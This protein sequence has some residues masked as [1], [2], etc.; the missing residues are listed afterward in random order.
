MFKPTNNPRIEALT[1]SYRD[2]ELRLSYMKPEKD[3]FGKRWCMWCGV[4][5]VKH[6]NRKYCSK[7][8]SL[9]MFAWAN[10]QKGNGL[11]LLL[12]RQAWKCNVCSYDYGPTIRSVWGYYGAKNRLVPTLGKDDSERFMRHFKSACDP[13]RKPEVDHV[14]PIYKG[15]QALGFDNHQAICYLCHKAKTKIDN[16]GPRKKEESDATV[17]VPVPDAPRVPGQ[18][19]EAG[20]DDN[21]P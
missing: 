9:A 6:F 19:G 1:K 14:V 16:S 2:R 7:A 10:P 4:I 20:E 3:A 5:E 18:P 12:K 21:L 11:H 17:H 15:G 13:S 8:C